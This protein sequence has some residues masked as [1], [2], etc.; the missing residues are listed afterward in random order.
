[1]LC[2]RQHLFHVLRDDACDVQDLR[3]VVDCVHHAAG[4]VDTPGVDELHDE[5]DDGEA[6]IIEDDDRMVARS[7]GG[8]KLSKVRTGGAQHNLQQHHTLKAR[9]WL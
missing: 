3:H 5:A 1:M 6:D 9:A 4:D 8:E 7:S 2:K